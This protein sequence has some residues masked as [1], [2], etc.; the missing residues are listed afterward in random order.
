MERELV[1]LF[2]AAKKAA[3]LAASDTVS[4]NGPEVSRCVD[5]LKQ[6]KD[7]PVSYDTL[8]STQ[9][10]RFDLPLPPLIYIYLILMKQ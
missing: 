5:A 9:V 10:F 6:L 1:D 2:E 8:V 4:S 3:D 7:F